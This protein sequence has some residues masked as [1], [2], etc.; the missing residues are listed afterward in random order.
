MTITASAT[1]KRVAVAPSTVTDVL[2]RHRR[3]CPVCF[4]LDFDLRQK[5]GQIA[6]LDRDRTNNAPSNLE[7]LCLAH[8]NDLDTRTSQAKGLSA[9]EVTHYAAEL[10]AYLAKNGDAMWLG[11]ERGAN[12]PR[13]AGTSSGCSIALYH[14]RLPVYREVNRFIAAVVTNARVELDDLRSFGVNT[15]Q[16]LYLYDEATS[17]FI[18]ETYEKAIQFRMSNQ[19][20]AHLQQTG[21][22]ISDDLIER[23]SSLLTWFSARAAEWR[24]HAIP[25]LT[26]RPDA[27]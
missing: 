4:G 20:L 18:L 5:D 1:G 23:E 16:A 3:R 6:H 14:L 11:T 2:T 24:R 13:T 22:Q 26:I 17:D 25:Y 27:A 19:R 7:F 10:R 21:A 12:A 15:D 8:H 9:A